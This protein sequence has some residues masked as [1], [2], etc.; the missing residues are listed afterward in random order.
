MDVL[1]K[2]QM[3]PGPEA[4]KREAR[5]RKSLKISVIL[6]LLLHYSL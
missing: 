3:S 5:Q 6:S 4:K 2:K 1:S